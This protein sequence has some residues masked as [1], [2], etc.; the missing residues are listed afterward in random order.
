[1]VSALGRTEPI[2]S[3]GRVNITARAVGEHGIPVHRCS[4]WLESHHNDS[5]FVTA[6]P[7][8]DLWSTKIIRYT[9]AFTIMHFPKIDAML[10]IDLLGALAS[11]VGLIVSIRALQAAKGARVAAQQAAAAARETA[12]RRNLAEELDDI[13]YKLQQVGHFLQLQEWIGVQIRIDEV[14][15]VCVVVMTRWPD[16][17][18]EDHMNGIR[19]ATS[20]IKSI[21]GQ[22][23]ELSQRQLSA[24]E[25]KRLTNTHLKA[26]GLI[27]AARGE[28]RK[29]EERGG[30][31][32]GN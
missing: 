31:E 29:E 21:A 7:A 15:A 27:N 28:A 9:G 23:A 25:R 1:M 8:S 10:L 17:L 18:S 16:H 30:N 2:W 12:I 13:S 4:Q 14:L 5:Y 3:V 20:L 6:T 32:D 26:S 11:G 24:A 19:T 22:S